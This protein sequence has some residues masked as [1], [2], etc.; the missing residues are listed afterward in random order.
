MK[1]HR[2]ISQWV[3]LSCRLR[4]TDF[5]S[6]GN[7]AE[8]VANVPDDIVY[9]AEACIIEP[10]TS[11]IVVNESERI[12]SDRP[13]VAEKIP[14]VV[15]AVDSAEFDQIVEITETPMAGI[16]PVVIPEIDLHIAVQQMRCSKDMLERL[17][18]NSTIQ[19]Q[20]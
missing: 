7:L 2:L 15:E 19:Q 4:K 20:K 9:S 16:C 11:R 13:N 5:I 6:V 10:I 18:C 14:S 17:V 1:C 3:L 8:A 12:Y